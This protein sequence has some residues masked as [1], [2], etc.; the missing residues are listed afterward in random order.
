MSCRTGSSARASKALGGAGAGAGASHGSGA[1]GAR[2]PARGGA[3]QLDA[4]DGRGTAPLLLF[5]L[6]GT[7]TSHTAV[8]RGAGC[9]RM[10]PGTHHLRRLQVRGYFIPTVHPTHRRAF[11]T[12]KW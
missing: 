4:S 7:L 2:A 6:N 11:A 9:N 1:G 10:R 8:R 3:R 12:D 5:D